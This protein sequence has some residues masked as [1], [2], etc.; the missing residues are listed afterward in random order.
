MGLF[1]DT[2]VIREGF[3]RGIAAAQER[4]NK[5]QQRKDKIAAKKA[6]D[7]MAVITRKVRWKEASRPPA[8][9]SAMA[10]PAS[11]GRSSGCSPR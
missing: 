9:A 10:S 7:E 4:A 5:E 1:L 11:C 3:A 2:F 8:T 6:R